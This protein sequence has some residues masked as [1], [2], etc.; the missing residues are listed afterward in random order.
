MWVTVIWEEGM[1]AKGFGKLCDMYVLGC[2]EPRNARL[3]KL[4]DYD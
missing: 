3:S 2:A 4:V 1:N